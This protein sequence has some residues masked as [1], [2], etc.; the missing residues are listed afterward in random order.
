MSAFSNTLNKIP[1]WT[2]VMGLM[3]LTNFLTFSLQNDIVEIRESQISELKQV[4]KESKMAYDAEVTTSQSLR[5][6]LSESYEEITKPDGTT[7][8]R[9]VKDVL[10]EKHA[11]Q[12]QRIKLEYEFKIKELEQKLAFEKTKK[13]T[14]TRKLSIG[15]GYNS[16]FEQFLT[17]QYDIWGPFGLVATGNPDSMS[18]GI[19]IGVRF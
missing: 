15:Y 16:D 6:Q 1:K 17:A 2:V 8:K 9:H 19:G 10:N 4:V 5:S 11:I 13:E 3:L 12:T 18:V 7:I 14:T